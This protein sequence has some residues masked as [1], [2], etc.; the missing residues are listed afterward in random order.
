MK[1]HQII[2]AKRVAFAV[3]IAAFLGGCAQTGTCSFDRVAAPVAKPVYV[4]APAP[5]PAPAP[6]PVLEPKA[7]R[8]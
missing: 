4:P 7:D 8:G 3:L 2:A 5:K 6:A 1:N